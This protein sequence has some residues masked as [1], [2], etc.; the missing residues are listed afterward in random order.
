M[1]DL[2]GG[3]IALSLATARPFHPTP[4]KK[5]RVLCTFDLSALLWSNC[6]ALIIV[7]LSS[8]TGKSMSFF[9]GSSDLNIFFKNL[10]K[11]VVET[12]EDNIICKH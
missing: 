9:N 1:W 3:H 6:I 7:T 8:K 5:P 11:I 10:A 12:C 2:L 4:E